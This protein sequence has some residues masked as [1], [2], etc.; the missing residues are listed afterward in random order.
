MNE[1]HPLDVI[2]LIFGVLFLGLG[3]PVLLLDTP[4]GVAHPGI[5]IDAKASIGYRNRGAARPGL[6]IPFVEA[7]GAP[8]WGSRRSPSA[9]STRK[10]PSVTRCSLP[11]CLQPR[12]HTLSEPRRQPHPVGEIALQV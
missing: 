7:S 12:V 5:G 10:T 1:R 3:I 6:L 2:S 8:A 4:R 9:P 11:A